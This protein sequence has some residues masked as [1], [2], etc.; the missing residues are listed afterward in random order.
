MIKFFIDRYTFLSITLFSKTIT[1]RWYAFLIMLGALG[2]YLVSRKEFKR[3][4]Y[5]DI[6]FFDSLFIYTLWVGVIGARIWF[7]LFY[8]LSYYLAHPIEILYVWNGGLAIQGGLVAGSLFVYFYCKANHYPFLKIIDIILPNVLIGQ[9]FGRWG[10]FVNQEC[11]GAEVTEEYFNGILS[12]LK[13]GMLINGHYYEPLF[14]YESMLCIIGWCLI[15]FVLRKKQN[16]RGDLGYCYL[17][18]YGVIRFF[19]EARRTDSLYLGPIKMAQLTSI[20]FVIVGCLGYVGLLRKLTNRNKPVVIFDFDG[21]LLDTSGSIFAGYE[22]CFRVYSDVSKFTDEIKE[23]VLGPALRTLFP[24]YFPGYDYD[25]LYKTYHDRQVEVADKLNKPILGSIETLKRLH[26]EGYHVGIVSTRTNEGI[27][28]LLIK[29]GMR[30]YVDSICGLNDVKNLKP[31]PEGIINMVDH[32]KWNRDVVMCGD[33][34]MDI[35]CGNNYGALT[36]AYLDNPN[37]SK[38][39]NDEA[40]YSVTDLTQIFDILN[41]DISFTYNKL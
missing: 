25:T 32:N 28:E 39:M 26:E 4:K 31:D 6:D 7:C 10:N 20:I 18:W 9:A 35:R 33:S 37:R 23:E 1:I 19:I 13:P 2:A 41:S 34:I 29:F 5:K 21:T 30:E 24:K 36:I 8:N 14:F 11:H 3:A 16:R 15:Y 22:E 40:N 17:M 38:Q 27:N 12:F